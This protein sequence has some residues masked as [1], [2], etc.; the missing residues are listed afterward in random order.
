MSVNEFD[1]TEG[2]S[3]TYFGKSFSKKSLVIS[4]SE[5]SFKPQAQDETK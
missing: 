5:K 1:Q 2:S 4:E 3:E